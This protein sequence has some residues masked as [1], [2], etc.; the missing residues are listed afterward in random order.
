MVVVVVELALSCSRRVFEAIPSGVHATHPP[1]AH[2]VGGRQLRSQLWV[3]NLLLE[4]VG[5]CVSWLE[6]RRVTGRLLC[7]A[8]GVSSED[9]RF[10]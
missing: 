8:C 3:L 6:Y 9:E 7:H 1:A 2:G 5:G 4:V 10:D